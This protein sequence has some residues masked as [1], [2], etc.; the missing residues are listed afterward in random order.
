MQAGKEIVDDHFA[1]DPR[2]RLMLGLALVLGVVAFAALARLTRR[3]SARETKRLVKMAIQKLPFSSAPK[4]FALWTFGLTLLVALTSHFGEHDHNAVLQL[5]DAAVAVL[6]ALLIALI[7]ALLSYVFLRVLPDVVALVI[8]LFFDERSRSAHAH[9]LGPEN[10]L[11]H[12][13]QSW[14][15]PLFSRPPP[16]Q[17]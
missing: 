17:L 14:P 8:A 12:L 10:T 11:R 2:V 4:H 9:V 3:A 15:P 16:L 5:G 13:F 6:T 7:A 1:I